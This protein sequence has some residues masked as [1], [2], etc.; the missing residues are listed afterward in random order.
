MRIDIFNTKNKYK[1]IYADPP[2]EY[3]ESGGGKR[4]T[5]GLPYPTM[6]TSEICKLP[7]LKISDD[8]SILFI[9]ATFRKLKECLEVISAWGFEYYGLGFDWVK[10]NKNSDTPFWG[11]GYYTR[12]NT[13]ICLIGVKKDKSKRIKPQARNVLSVVHSKIENHSKKPDCIRQYISVICGDVPKIEL[14]ARKHTDGWDCWGN[15]VPVNE[16]GSEWLDELLGVD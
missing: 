11:M 10:T 14:F 15:E 7:I 1:V 13:E 9:W 5:A 4:G 12:Q 6:N 3:K 2:W 8:T 16:S